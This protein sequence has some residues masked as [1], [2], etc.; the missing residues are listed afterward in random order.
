MKIT[1]RKGV[2]DLQLGGPP[3]EVEPEQPVDLPPQPKAATDRV[4]VS[5]VARV[6]AALSSGIG[7]GEG[8]RTEKV[9]ALR[10]QIASG[11]YPIDLEAVARS[12]LNGVLAE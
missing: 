3:P 8:F 12:F 7:E 6:L 10:E 5:D 1:D 11:Q 2:P 9:N 4:D